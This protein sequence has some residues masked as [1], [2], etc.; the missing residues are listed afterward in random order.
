MVRPLL[1]LVASLALA[2]LPSADSAGILHSQRS[3]PGDL[4]IGG[5]LGGAPAGVTR[6][7]RYRDLLGLPQE[8]YTV[9]DDTNIKGN[10]EIEGVALATLARLLGRTPDDEL[11]VAICYDRYRANYPRDYL[12]AH[13]PILVLRIN[14]QVRDHWPPSESGG[15]LGPYLVSHPAFKPA[16]KVL[17][18]E[19]EPQI[20]FGVTR[21]EVRRE[22]TVFGAIRPPGDLPLSLAVEQGYIVARQDCF[23]CHNMGNE[24]G[25]LAGRSWLK[26]A[27]VAQENDKRFKQTIHDP[28]T[29]SP[30]ARMPAHPAYDEATLDA[31]AAYFKTFA[32]VTRKQ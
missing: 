22:S 11:I 30:K 13:H 17:S 31:L 18:H 15:P 1:W 24:G 5:D 25:T 6:F 14:G 23:R 32:H 21:I 10:T 28:R 19:D 27:A 9:T 2:G 29:F 12:N 8:N 16:F 26:L 20:P 7:I 3:S 4:E